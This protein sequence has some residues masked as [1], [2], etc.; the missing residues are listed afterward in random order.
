M[1]ARI[2][3]RGDIPYNFVSLTMIAIQV[4]RGKW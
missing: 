3:E 2:V 1:L 4:L